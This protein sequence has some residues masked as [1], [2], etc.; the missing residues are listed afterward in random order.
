MLTMFLIVKQD[1]QFLTSFDK[2]LKITFIIFNLIHYKASL[3]T[4]QRTFIFYLLC[5]LTFAILL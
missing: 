3:F 4:T 1:N 2:L 5:Y